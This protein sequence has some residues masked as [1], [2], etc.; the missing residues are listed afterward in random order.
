MPREAGRGWSIPGRASWSER[1][2][3]QRGPGFFS[4]R[5]LLVVSAGGVLLAALAMTLWAALFGGRRMLPDT[6]AARSGRLM[7][8]LRETGEIHAEQVTDV[9]SRAMGEVSWLIEEGRE[10]EPG[11]LLVKLDDTDILL[12]IEEQ[13]RQLGPRRSEYERAV[14]EVE[15]AKDRLGLKVRQAELRLETA[16]W[17]RTDLLRHPTDDERQ[18]A[19]LEV[20]QATLRHERARRKYERA[21]EMN[22]RGLLSDTEL[23]RSRLEA[24][25]AEAN[26]KLARLRFELKKKGPAHLDV[27]SARLQAELAKLA[28]EE[29]KASAET[30]LVMAE[31]SAEIARA[32]LDKAEGHLERLRRE[33]E[34]CSIRAPVAGTVR[35]KEVW[36][37]TGQLSRIHLGEIARWG[38]A[39]CSVADSSRLQARILVNEVDALRIRPSQKAI[40]RPVALRGVELPG[41]VRSVTR[42]AFDK[43]EKLGRLALKKAGR[44]GVSVVEVEV[45]VLETD[46]RVKLGF[47]AMVE[48]VLEEHPSAILVPTSA[49]LYEG[50]AAYCFSPEGEKRP[51][52]VLGSNE[53]E[54][55]VEGLKKGEEVVRDGA[56]ALEGTH[57]RN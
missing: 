23:R 21:S 6:A 33:L 9:Y 11:E 12:R 44:A 51:V 18:L 30:D 55:A 34:N 19:W 39:P 25:D 7:V 27:E 48:I 15:A 1:L 38:Q 16:E 40:V 22:A 10:V 52:R 53:L 29:A 24:L 4:Q 5:R 35:L 47:T 42:Q 36:K 2:R 13:E 14:A 50:D 20:E 3:L 41:R 57:S 54:C 46:P 43:N 8:S 32:R 37:G 17:R 45:E 31:N 28:L 49:L 26:L 56:R